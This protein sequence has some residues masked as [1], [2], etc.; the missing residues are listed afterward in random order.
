ML[1][2]LTLRQKIGQMIMMGFPAEEVT[3]ELAEFLSEYKIGNII[4]FTRNVAT[5]GQLQRLCA[6]LQENIKRNTGY[7]AF[8][9]VDQEG[10]MVA[11]LPADAVSMPAAMAVAATGNPQNAYLAGKITAEELRSLGV[12]MNLA[13][14]MDINSNPNNPVIGVRSFGDTSEIVTNF[15]TALMKGLQD[16]GVLPVIKHFPGHGDTSVDSHLG[17]PKVE[18][19]LE[20][21]EQNELVPFKAAIREGGCGVMSSHIL[22]PAIEKEAL[23]CTMS[24]TML[25]GLL[26]NELGFD[27]LV[28]TDCLEMD[29]IQKYYGTAKGALAAIRAGANLLCISHTAELVKETVELVER[30]IMSG[31]LSEE[32]IDRAV[33]KILK[34][35]SE[36]AGDTT[37]IPSGSNIGS[38]FH[39][40]EIAR[41]SEES[42]TL[43]HRGNAELSVKG[44]KT[45][46]VGCY[47]NRTT[48]AS[49]SVNKDFS[50]ASYMAN[51]LNGDSLIT[52]SDPSEQDIEAVVKQ[53][54]NYECVVIGLFNGKK[55]NGQVRLANSLCRTGTNVIA[56]S[57]FNPYDL[58]LVDE[59]ATKLAA[60]EYTILSFSTLVKVFNGELVP[61]GKLSVKI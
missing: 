11:R 47:A 15:G 57:L 6:D 20:E 29:A 43:V 39:K 53:A 33:E 58:A 22:F 24:Y 40:A 34:F 12:N 8:I 25:T 38:D 42:I 35:K 2:N 31:D 52:P 13:P 26:K 45:F 7:A 36:Y 21:L 51:Q 44:K 16:G 14:D 48:L 61:Q 4:L 30:A 17:L 37:K 19:T 60:Y 23:P 32:L 3:P 46:F 56:V 5:S 59:K 55:N 27:G 1:Q 50:F 28:L 41:I 18:K 49:S 10:G 9:S 54:Q